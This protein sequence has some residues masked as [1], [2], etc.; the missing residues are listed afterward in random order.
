MN[1]ETIEE[2]Y[3][4]GK[5]NYR[6]KR[7]KDLD[8]LVDAVDEDLFNQDERLPYWAELWPAAIGFSRFIAGQKELVQNKSVLELGCGLGLT[9]MVLTRQAPAYFVASDYEQ[10][11]LDFAAKN[12]KLN[13]LPLPEFRLL[14]WRDPILN[15]VFDCIVASDIL[16]ERRFFGPLLNLVHIYLKDRGRI[17]IAEPNRPVAQEF[18]ERLRVDK[19]V[20]QMHLEKVMQ[21]GKEIQVSIHQIRKG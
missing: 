12:F 3:Q 14:D 6:L 1:F 10:D 8:K 16:Y 9:S 21:N 19:Y 17:I 11:A 13:R 5:D 18:F 15:G 2:A 20:T 7:V 4:F